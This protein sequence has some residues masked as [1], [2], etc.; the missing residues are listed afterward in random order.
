[1]SLTVK[2]HRKTREPLPEEPGNRSS[3]VPLLSLSLAR[4]MLEHGD[5]IEAETLCRDALQATPHDSE[6]LKLLGRSL[7]AQQKNSE[8]VA[9]LG[10]ALLGAPECTASQRDL[11]EA[12]LRN[13]SPIS[14]LPFLYRAK[15]LLFDHADPWLDSLTDSAL[16]EARRRG[17]ALVDPTDSKGQTTLVFVGQ[18]LDQTELVGGDDLGAV[19]PPVGSDTSETRREERI[20]GAHLRNDPPNRSP[21]NVDAALDSIP[22]LNGMLMLAATSKEPRVSLGVEEVLKAIVGETRRE[23]AEVD[24]LSETS[25]P[26]ARGLRLW[27]AV[28]LVLLSSAGG[29]IASLA[30]GKLASK[31]SR[32]LQAAS[33]ALYQDTEAGY[34]SVLTTLKT[35][36]GSRPVAA[37]A[38]S[39]A[40]LALDHRKGSGH[41]S[42]AV[43]LLESL[44]QE[45]RDLELA[46]GAR[47][48]L[49][50]AQQSQDFGEFE[51]T[52][53]SIIFTKPS[54]FEEAL[55][56]ADL[57]S[58]FLG[59][60]L[61]RYLLSVGDD[62]GG[63]SALLKALELDPDLPLARRALARWAG[64]KQD[65]MHAKRHLEVLVSLDP[66]DASAI[67]DRALVQAAL[68]ESFSEE[69]LGSLARIVDEDTVSVTRARVALIL[70]VLALANDDWMH[71][72]TLLGHVA[73]YPELAAA[74]LKLISAAGHGE[75]AERLAHIYR[76]MVSARCLAEAYAI[77]RIV[78]VLP[79]ANPGFAFD[80]ERT[81]NSELARIRPT[82]GRFI[83]FEINWARAVPNFNDIQWAEDPFVTAEGLVAATLGFAHLAEGRL[84]EGRDQ[85][86]AAIQSGWISGHLRLALAE[87]QLTLGASDDSIATLSPI[88][89]GEGTKAVSA[90]KVAARAHF[91]AGRV[92]TARD[93][94]HALL[95]AD[96]IAADLLFLA[97]QIS[98]E[99]DRLDEAIT[100]IEKSRRLE[101]NGEHVAA[102]KSILEQFVESEPDEERAAKVKSLLEK[103]R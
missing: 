101:P 69:E 29:A 55:R 20:G 42:S 44:S 49:F 95:G 71:A 77:T 33:D 11:A 7:L 24:E 52:E 43:R 78:L 6:V 4:A 99:E 36:E 62:E 63:V 96:I 28:V 68:G 83:P 57:H 47:V 50:K 102:A 14:A 26:K 88:I 23:Y 66:Q 18:P 34:E 51:V 86:T 60:I 46:L 48:Y 1:M 80:D 38:F 8:A 54:T 40:A 3:S 41:I 19:F 98:L 17:F 81:L 9:T 67:A 16:V 73:P 74:G 93:M 35:V 56:S 15:S 82:P 97:G 92:G 79:E 70:A 53:P 58:P 22:A 65:L 59:A 90:R 31:E 76:E 45:E 32:L 87:T 27:A 25:M 30:M 39:H 91:Q 37:R 12:L 10:Q 5:L 100:W 84:E 64:D 2:L 89:D 85:L 72:E 61:G 21:A 94:V 75:A 103:L 13:G